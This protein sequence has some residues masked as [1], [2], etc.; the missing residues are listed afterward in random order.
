MTSLRLIHSQRWTILPLLLRFKANSHESNVNPN[1]HYSNKN[2]KKLKDWTSFFES[3]TEL[4][5]NQTTFDT[6]GSAQTVSSH[7][8]K[9]SPF[10][11][12]VVV[13]FYGWHWLLWMF[14]TSNI[15]PDYLYHCCYFS[16][17]T[18]QDRA[19]GQIF[20]LYKLLIL[21]P[22]SANSTQVWRERTSQP[23][24]LFSAPS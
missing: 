4:A 8:P 19:L 9:H 17:Q 11:Y 15:E 22:R 7:L 20:T 18:S 21:A 24:H 10:K 6:C 23:A 16:T 13:T 14:Y 12:N 1:I 5:L 3:F 2:L